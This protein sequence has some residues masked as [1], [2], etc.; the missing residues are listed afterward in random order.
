ML[1]VGTGES[2]NE[3]PATG[4]AWPDF[5]ERLG[6]LREAIDLIRLLWTKERVTFSGQFYRAENATIYDRPE[7]PVPVFI[8]AAGPTV[9]K[10]VGRTADGFICTSGKTTEFYHKTVLPNLKEGLSSGGRSDDALE[11]M[12]EMK[13]SF[14]TDR[15]RALEDTRYW[16]ALAL[17]ADEKISVEDPLQMERMAAELPIERVASRWI[18]S[19]D[20]QDQ[21]ER[22]RPYVEM[23]F[24]HLVFH[25][26]GGDQ[27]RFLRLYASDVLP[28]LRKAF[29]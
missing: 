29:T 15:E 5:K 21:I 3:V 1:G 10:Y 27:E 19:S 28:L 8:S 18:V 14:D 11:R 7:K 9:A 17:S 25:A 2:L 12:I 23:G 6:R 13:V 16:A 24:N 4:I 26:P 22:I 20:P